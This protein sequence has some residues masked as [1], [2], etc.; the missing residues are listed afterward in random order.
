METAHLRDRA[1][2]GG[3]ASTRNRSQRA[4]NAMPSP[5]LEG[6]EEWNGTT[7]MV[8]IPELPLG[9]HFLC[10]VHGVVYSTQSLS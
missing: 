7:L 4:W 8:L 5:T 1:G 2:G 10:C 3:E 9:K 6:D